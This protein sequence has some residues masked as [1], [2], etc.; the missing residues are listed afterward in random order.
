MEFRA[1]RGVKVV[2]WI[3]YI[4]NHVLKAFGLPTLALRAI[5]AG[6]LC[7]FLAEVQEELMVGEE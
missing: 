7:V 4:S 1:G 5:F 6:I 3:T 2:S